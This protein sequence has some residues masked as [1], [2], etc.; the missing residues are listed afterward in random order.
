[1]PPGRA[2]SD[3]GRRDLALDIIAN[4]G[5][6]EAIRLR[7]DIYWAARRWRE[8]SEQIELYYADRW[9]DFK[10]LDPQEKGDVIRAVLGYALA[11]DSLGL[12][13]FREK[14]APLMSGEADQALMETASKPAST[15]SADFAQIAKMAASVDTLD[16]FLRDMKAR[17]P[18]SSTK[19]VL[20]PGAERADPEPTGVLPA[21]AGLKRA[22]AAR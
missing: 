10:P 20:P 4:V 16:G 3:V 7:S 1:M 12:A 14:Y 5:G 13:R 21:I 11:E 19:A 9:R 22:D 2:Q 6:R 17:F 15:N 18:D 8:A